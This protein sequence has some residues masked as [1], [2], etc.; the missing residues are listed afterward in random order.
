MDPEHG[1]SAYEIW[2]T[3][4]L[5]PRRASAGATLAAPRRVGDERAAGGGRARGEH[6][7]AVASGVPAHRLAPRL[8]D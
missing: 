1:W 8:V 4:V 7:D 3:R 2:R 6:R 5:L